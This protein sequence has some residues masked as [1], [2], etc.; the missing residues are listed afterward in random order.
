M[1]PAFPVR[2]FQYSTA[3]NI[4]GLLA[5]VWFKQELKTGQALVT[6]SL[7]SSKTWSPWDPAVGN[8]LLFFTKFL[9][10]GD[11]PQQKVGFYT[12]LLKTKTKKNLANIQ[13]LNA[14]IKNIMMPK[15]LFARALA[16]P[17]V[18][19]LLSSQALRMRF[20]QC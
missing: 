20:L 18:K 5:S 9:L 12:K 3:S 17:N 10:L 11:C 6:C 2:G 4:A 15:M 19:A 16:M 13:I 14:I 8:T 7:H 1:S